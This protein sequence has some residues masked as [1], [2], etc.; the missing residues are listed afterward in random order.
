MP[1]VETEFLFRAEIDLQAPQMV[2]QT[3]QGN[4]IIFVVERGTFEG[5]KL[6]G[7]FLAGG[8]D[9]FLLRPDGVGELDVRVT[10]RTDDGQLVYM[11]YRGILDA[12]PAVM[13]RILRGQPVER[14]E[15][16][17]RTAPT[18]QTAA[19][20]YDWLNRIQAIGIGEV[21]AGGVAYD[22]YAIR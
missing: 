11:A 9:W 6:K 12:A 4:R 17:F 7:E 5:P 18:F 8:G 15:Y 1:E 2:G 20:Q 16:Y 19:P 10:L 3:P 14:S 22:A 13:A 21:T